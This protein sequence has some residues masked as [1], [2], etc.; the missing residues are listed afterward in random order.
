MAPRLQFA[1]GLTVERPADEPN[2]IRQ[3]AAGDDNDV[4]GRPLFAAAGALAKTRVD[5]FSSF[6]P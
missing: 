1:S 3:A 6:L 5:V 4:N 2:R